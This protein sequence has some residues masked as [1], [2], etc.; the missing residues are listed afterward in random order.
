MKRSTSETIRNAYFN[1]E[2]LSRSSRL[3]Q[4]GIFRQKDIY[5][6]RVLVTLPVKPNIIRGSVFYLQ[7]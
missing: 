7:V 6:V 5:N 1:M 3:A 2:R 4:R